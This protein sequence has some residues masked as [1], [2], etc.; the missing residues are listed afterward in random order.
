MTI[1]SYEGLDCRSPHVLYRA[2]RN[3]WSISR[4]SLGVD[5]VEKLHE[6]GAGYLVLIRNKNVEKT[7][8]KHLEKYPL[9]QFT[10]GSKNWPI[11]IYDL[12][13]ELRSLK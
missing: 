2:R 1:I 12:N 4:A 11:R 3:G 6:L 8:A 5:L 9:D 7:L 13:P 10:F